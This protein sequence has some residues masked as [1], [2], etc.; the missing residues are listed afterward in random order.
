MKNKVLIELIVQDINS[1]YNVYIP[2]K[3]KIGSIIELLNRSVFELSNGAFVGNNKTGLYS[4]ETGERYA[5][6]SLVRMTNIRNGA[7]LILL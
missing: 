6:D 5:V 7:S 3:K 2:V 1:T 4:R